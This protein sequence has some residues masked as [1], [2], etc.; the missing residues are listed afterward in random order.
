M[1]RI[2]IVTHL[3][4]TF[5]PSTRIVDNVHFSIVYVKRL[6]NMHRGPSLNKFFCR[7]PF[8]SYAVQD[9]YFVPSRRSCTQPQELPHLLLLVLGYA[10]NI[11][12]KL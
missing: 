10:L 11:T 4:D 12:F 8:P 5:V 3:F 2:I 7:F 6:A 1:H 9:G